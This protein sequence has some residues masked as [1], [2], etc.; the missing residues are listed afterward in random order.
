[1]STHHSMKESGQ[2]Y[3]I[4]KFVVPS[5]ACTEFLDQVKRTH[6][7]LRTLPGFVQDYIL[8]QTGGPGAFNVVT[9]AIWDSAEAIEAARKAV[10]ARHE[11][12]GFNPQE[13]LAR[14]GIKADLA[15]YRQVDT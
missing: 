1:M 15:T 13:M 12:V 7:F 14:L 2:I 8:E 11:A 10:M 4:D 6:E 9:I 3:R 5:S